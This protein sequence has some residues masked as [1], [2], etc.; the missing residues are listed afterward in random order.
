MTKRD[1][2]IGLYR[3]G[4][5]I[6]K[7]IKQLKVPKS[8]VY[9]AVRRYKELGNTKDRP[10]SGRPRSC[11]T[12]SNIKAVRER[13]RRDPKR[14]MRKM[15][16]DLKMDPKSMRTIVKTDLKLSPLKLK[17]RQHL[18]VLQKRKRAERAG[19][20]L[21]LLKSGTQKGEIV[22]SD[23]KMFT[24]EAKFNPQNDRVLARH[25]EDVPEDML[26]VYRRQ[27]PASV[28]V[29]AAVSKTWKSP[30][31]FVKEGAKVNTNV[32]IDDI[33]APA[34]RDMKEHF[35][36]ENFTFQQ[37]GAPSH[38]SNKTQAWCR[39]NFPRF[40]SK[41]LWPPSSPD[42]NPMDFSVWSMLETEACRSPHT[43]VESLKVS[44]VKAWA[45][46]PQ[47]KLRAAVESFRGRLERVIAVEGGH[48][49]K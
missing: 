40:W 15:A 22:F 45:K 11:R 21:N 29:W 18:T 25:S 4:T 48:I 44:L 13:V 7:I 26:T 2:I 30:L 49:E 35:K 6:S 3:A 17:K 47:K 20:L 33:L 28:M 24:V 41:E 43:T 36:R 10:K 39:D 23:E 38:T 9:D 27:K 19:L 42:L 46:I 34:L 37:D 14:S 5:P 32:Y 12:K 31:I 8:T 1:A 16:R